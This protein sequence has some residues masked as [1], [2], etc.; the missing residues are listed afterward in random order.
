MPGLAALK[1]RVRATLLAECLTFA[2]TARFPDNRV[3]VSRRA[4]LEPAGFPDDHILVDSLKC[5]QLL[6]SHV[7]LDRVIGKPQ[8]ASIFHTLDQVGFT[9]VDS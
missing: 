3:T 1:A 4:P 6:R 8:R 7:R 2:G 9:A 5:L